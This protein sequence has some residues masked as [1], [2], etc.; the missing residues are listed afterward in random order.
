M[1]AKE[2]AKLAQGRPQPRPQ[3][4]TVD[5]PKIDPVSGAYAA[6]CGVD[7]GGNLVLANF[8]LLEVLTKVGQF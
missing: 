2:L 6:C 3:F 4:Q 5:R 8:E 7:R 1:I